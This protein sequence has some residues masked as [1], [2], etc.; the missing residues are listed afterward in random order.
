MYLSEAIE[1]RI[2]GLCDERN[3]TLNRLATICG[4]TQ[5]TLNNIKNRNNRS[6]TVLTIYRIC[7]GLEIDINEFF[8]DKLFDNIDDE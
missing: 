6:T 8:D 7:F 4:I 3:I 5:S 2:S 1:K